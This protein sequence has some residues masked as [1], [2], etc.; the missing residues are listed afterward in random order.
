MN[1]FII[2]GCYTA[3]VTPFRDNGDLDE[4]ALRRLVDRQINAG[5]TGLVPCGTTGESVTLDPQEYQRV[6]DI[7][8]RQSAG[9]VPVI[10]GAGGNNTREVIRMALT[11][12]DLGADA[13]LS[14]CPYYNKPS[15]AGLVSHYESIAT[16]V[17]IPIVLYNVPGRTGVNITAETTL[18]LAAVPNIIAVKEASGNLTQIM[19]ILQHRPEGFYVVSGDDALTLPLLA[20]GGDGVISVISNQV[21]GEFT[22]MVAAAHNGDW[23]TARDIHYRLLNLMQLNF[24]ESNP[25]PVKTS[26]ALMGL[27]SN[28]VR[29]PLSALT[30]SSL[31]Q[32]VVELQHLNLISDDAFIISD[33]SHQS[34][35]ET[36]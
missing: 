9:R 31:R 35:M 6:L 16:A 5:I 30:T 27:I 8:I 29:Q 25:V 34:I 10:C 1:P 23:E 28:T 14:V 18:K 36:A 17:D 13:L 26:L 12:Q 32:L 19:T 22:Q 7:V 24:L 15:Q 20:A 3:L 11:A 33:F 4:D 2:N 21:P